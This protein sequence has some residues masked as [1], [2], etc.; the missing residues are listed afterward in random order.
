MNGTKGKEGGTELFRIT[1]IKDV[2]INL[3]KDPSCIL[4]NIKNKII[5]PIKPNSYINTP[6]ND[7]IDV[8]PLPK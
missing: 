1:N 6:I 4:K 3:L 5:I 7:I 2:S 8:D